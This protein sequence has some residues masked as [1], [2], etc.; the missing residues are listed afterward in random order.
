VDLNLPDISGF[1][2]IKFMR[3]QY[4]NAP[5]VALT[6]H[7]GK[8]EKLIALEAGATEFASKPISAAYL[9]EILLRCCG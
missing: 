3:E 9:K 4:A 5:I 8:E 7:T 1:E 2:V 6:V